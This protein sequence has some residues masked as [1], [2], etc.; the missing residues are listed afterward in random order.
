MI[1]LLWSGLLRATGQGQRGK[2]LSS[3][4][5]AGS[6]SPRPRGQRAR[7]GRACRPEDAA[8]ARCPGGC[9]FA[10]RRACL[11]CP[12]RGPAGSCGAQA[13]RPPHAW[14]CAGRL[15]LARLRRTGAGESGEGP[16]GGAGGRPSRLASRRRLR[17]P[18]AS[19]GA[20][21]RPRWL[22]AAPGGRDQPH[23]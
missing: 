7:G 10:R 4:V 23:L 22:G 3:V 18:P 20:G 1:L 13:P 2:A 12:P 6:S 14:S 19:L 21:K 9:S 8:A 17:E 15:P 5:R 11:A 16:R